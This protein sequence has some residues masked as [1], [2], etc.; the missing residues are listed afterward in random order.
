MEYVIR[1]GIIIPKEVKYG[2]YKT[3]QTR[4]ATSSAPL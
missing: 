4:T 3:N 2:K 1:K